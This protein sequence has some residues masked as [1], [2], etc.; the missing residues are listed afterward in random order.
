MQER[1]ALIKETQL[2]AREVRESFSARLPVKET[3]EEFLSDLEDR[4]AELLEKM[5]EEAESE[6]TERREFQSSLLAEMRTLNQ[7]LESLA[8]R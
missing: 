3:H 8:K 6:R 5:R 2:N 1:N 7:N 4:N